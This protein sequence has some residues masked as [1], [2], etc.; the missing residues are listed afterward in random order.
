MLMNTGS[1]PFRSKNGLLTTVASSIR[2]Q[3]SYA[4]EGSIFVAGSAV[5]WLRD[6]L[7]IVESSADT[8]S[9]AR[10]LTGNDGVYFVPAFVGLGTPYWNQDA[11]GTITGL[12]RGTTRAH[13]A[14]ATL[15]SIAYQ[16]RD[17]LEAMSKDC[18][19]PIRSIRVDGGM[20]KNDF[21]LSCLS[22]INRVE[23][24][25][26]VLQ[27]TTALGAAYLAGLGIGLWSDISEIGSSWQV[28]RVFQPSITDDEADNLYK[29]WKRSVRAALAACDD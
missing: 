8:D 21:F 4:L 17:V 16:T 12:T 11:R 24:V 13:I 10:S 29:G 2:G 26:P 6:N 15:E 14:R 7:K 23:V 28:E 22:D 20:V 25:R 18:S 1:S 27:E 19:L 3:Y 9:L 5:Q